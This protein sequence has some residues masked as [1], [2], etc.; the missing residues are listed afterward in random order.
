MTVDMMVPS[1]DIVHIFL[2]QLWVCSMEISTTNYLTTQVP[3][4]FHKLS[5]KGQVSR[6]LFDMT[7]PHHNQRMINW[8]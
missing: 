4:L 3:I 8:P 5:F 1:N 2:S 7:G 6:I